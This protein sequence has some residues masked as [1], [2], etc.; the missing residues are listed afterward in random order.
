VRAQLPSLEVPVLLLHGDSSPFI[1]VNVMVD[2]HQAIRNSRLQV[3]QRAR[4]GLPF[5]HARECAQ[6][7]R[8]FLDAERG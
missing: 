8:R 6:A 7:L 4:H 5:S 2:M 3:F 1:P